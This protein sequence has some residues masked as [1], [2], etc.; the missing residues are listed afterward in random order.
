MEWGGS[1]DP[2]ILYLGIKW[3]VVT[4]TPWSLYARKRSPATHGLGGC[5]AST[6]SLDTLDKITLFFPYPESNQDYSVI[7]PAA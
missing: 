5:V 3:K 2:S 7:Y 6:A 4:F 1:I